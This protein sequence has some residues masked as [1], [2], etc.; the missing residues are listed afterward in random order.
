M[1]VNTAKQ[2][3]LTAEE[4]EKLFAEY[5]KSR[6]Q[7]L[8][9]QLV[10]AHM[11][12]VHHLVRKF[13]RRGVEY[14][15]LVQVGYY[16]LIKAVERYDASQNTK[17]STYAT[18]TIIGEIKHYF[19][20]KQ[21]SVRVPRRIKQL[22]ARIYSVIPELMQE[23]QRTPRAKDIAQ[24]LGIDED[25][26]IEAMELGQG[27]QTASLDTIINS[28]SEDKEVTLLNV[29]GEEDADLSKVEDRAALARAL[30]RLDSDERKLIQLRYF[31]EL[32]QREVGERLGISQ[33]QVSR[34]QRRILKKLQK[35]MA[36]S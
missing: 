25:D 2:N 34:L 26:V 28:D 13:I 16:A 3:T 10:E 1:T 36:E 6:D 15:D 20:D 19:R 8:R 12:L 33:M 23:L 4:I 17:F 21:W 24:H 7:R 18:P 35:E 27:Y 30:S 5:Q 32:S 11:Y 29:L 31:D 22:S 9:N 14:D